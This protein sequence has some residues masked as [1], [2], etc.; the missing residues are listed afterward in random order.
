MKFDIPIN[1]SI[2]LRKL[3]DKHGKPRST[4][5]NVDNMIIDVKV[6]PTRIECC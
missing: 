5:Y 1:Q 6:I 4:A 3:H 2:E